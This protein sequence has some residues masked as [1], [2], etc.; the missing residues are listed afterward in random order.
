MLLPPLLLPFL[1]PLLLLLTLPPP[2]LLRRSLALPPMYILP[3]SRSHTLLPLLPRC[4]VLPL[5]SYAVPV[6]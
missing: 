4:L 3:S 6:K 2:A 5:L 1:L